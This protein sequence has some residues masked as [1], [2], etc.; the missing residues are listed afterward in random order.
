MHQKTIKF[1]E[2]LQDCVTQTETTE[3]I[4]SE[5]KT[6]R[7][8]LETK[9]YKVAD[10]WMALSGLDINGED[11]EFAYYYEDLNYVVEGVT[12]AWVNNIDR[13]YILSELKPAIDQIYEALPE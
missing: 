2:S 10:G 8:T 11:A 1:I 4:L 9:G 3:R 5:H 12:N 13:P 7:E 6:I